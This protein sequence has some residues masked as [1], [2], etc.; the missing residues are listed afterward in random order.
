MKNMQIR[1]R[2]LKKIYLSTIFH[3]FTNFKFI[4]INFIFL[5]LEMKA[6][7]FC[8]ESE[9]YFKNSTTLFITAALYYSRVQYTFIQED[10]YILVLGFD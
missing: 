6:N 10:V 9:I 5:S 2:N 1:H 4:F 8:K 3:N 7:C